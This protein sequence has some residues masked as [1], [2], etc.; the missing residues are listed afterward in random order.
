[1]ESRFF[2]KTSTEREVAHLYEH[3]FLTALDEKLA[4]AGYLPY[5]D[6]V[7]SGESLRGEIEF[8][9]R[10]LSPTLNEKIFSI[11][12]ELDKELKFSSERIR[13]AT[14]QIS[15]EKQLDLIYVN[16]TTLDKLKSL[17]RRTWREG[18]AIDIDLN[19]EGQES[20]YLKYAENDELRFYNISIEVSYGGKDL[21]LGVFL[22]RVVMELYCRRLMNEFAC[23]YD[24][25]SDM[26]DGTH[27]SLASMLLKSEKSVIRREMLEK[28]ATEL[29]EELKKLKNLRKIQKM[30]KNDGFISIKIENVD[31]QKV[32]KYDDWAKYAN[33]P[34]IA[35]VLK[36]VKIRPLEITTE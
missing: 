30:L 16:P 12:Q 26:V 24:G 35:S 20:E 3:I 19:D 5:L 1:M 11:L 29:L 32:F 4:K 15:A 6:Y 34:K 23:S 22:S 8:S 33:L 18:V 27:V 17:R 2:T 31:G 10:S 25:A 7:T 9:F 28:R 21:P 13:G 36:G 14:E